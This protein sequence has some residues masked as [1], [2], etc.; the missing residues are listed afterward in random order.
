[1]SSVGHRSLLFLLTVLRVEQPRQREKFH[2]LDTSRC[3]VGASRCHFL[4]RT[5]GQLPSA[6][7][8]RFYSR[9]L[10]GFQAVGVCSMTPPPPIST[11]LYTTQI[12]LQSILSIRYIL[13][14]T[15]RVYWVNIDKCSLS[16]CILKFGS[17]WKSSCI[18]MLS[19]FSPLAAYCIKYNPEF[20]RVLYICLPLQ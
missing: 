16:I 2:A 7:L 18:L 8:S 15:R 4:K 1:M 14:G 17:I 3:L 13:I 10:L 12:F 20:R 5:V 9:S 6:E 19:N 11:S